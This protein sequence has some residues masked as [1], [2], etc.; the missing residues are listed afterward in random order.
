MGGISNRYTAEEAYSIIIW[1]I[2]SPP[3]CLAFI[4]LCFR[5]SS[6]HPIEPIISP[7]LPF[8]LGRPKL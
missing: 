4:N 7:L 8:S 6:T 5:F 2:R 3:N 1:A